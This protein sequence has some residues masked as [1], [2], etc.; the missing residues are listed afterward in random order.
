MMELG[1]FGDGAM[2]L[3]GLILL[4][5]LSGGIVAV[6]L[7]LRASTSSAGMWPDGGRLPEGER[8]PARS[9]ERSERRPRNPFGLSGETGLYSSVEDRL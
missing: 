9:A 6:S 5:A 2:N 4:A 1:G 3:L 8:H 7:R